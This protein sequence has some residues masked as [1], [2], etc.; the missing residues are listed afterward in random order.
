MIDLSKI[1]H[2]YLYPGKTD[3]RYGI[4][5]LRR[6]IANHIEI[7]SLYV[8]C[9]Y[10]LT[11]LKILEVEDNA[12][13]LY[14]K[15]LLRGKFNYPSCGNTSSLSVDE[16]KFIIDGMNLIHKIEGVKCIGKD[17]FWKFTL[18]YL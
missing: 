18:L 12:I 4:N 13:W 8:F 14:Q 1:K 11:Q 17:V 7:N 6:I 16:I 15:K 5:G 3:F 9:N 2:V 10:D